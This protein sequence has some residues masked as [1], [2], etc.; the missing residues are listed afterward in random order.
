VKFKESLPQSSSTLIFAFCRYS[1]QLIL[2]L[3]LRLKVGDLVVLDVPNADALP[4]SGGRENTTAG[5]K[6][7]APASARQ[8]ERIFG[9]QIKSTARKLVFGTVVSPTSSKLASPYQAHS[10]VHLYGY[11]PKCGS[12]F[13]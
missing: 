9:R 7:D 8:V 12:P 13:P 3:V 11:P 10:V 6:K 5:E 2:R 1:P 4:E